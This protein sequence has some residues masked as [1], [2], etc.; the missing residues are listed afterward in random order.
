MGERGIIFDVQ[1]FAVHDGPGIR[2]LVFLKGCPLACQWCSNPESRRFEPDLLFDEAKCIR[3]WSCVPACP[4]AALLAGPEGVRTDRMRC[5]GCGQ[6]VDACCAGARLVKG[7]DV[8]AEWV[9]REVL[10]DEAFFSGSGGGVTLGG[11]EPLA[12]PDFAASIL[13]EAK[14][15]GLHTV[16]ETCGHVPWSAIAQSLPWT[17]LFLFDLKHVDPAK[18]HLYTGGDVSIILSNLRRLAATG[19]PIVIR[20]PVIPTFND[21]ATEI[22]AIANTVAALGL[23]RV[24]LLPYHALGQSKYRLLGTANPFSATVPLPMPA[25]VALKDVAVQAGVNV[26]IEG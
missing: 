9:M 24:H 20:V 13:H 6:C 19:R 17:D 11:G 12:Q 16:V 15:R 3:C 23:Q 14:R 26:Q 21:T 18:H 8:T 1:R 7:M 4:K 5:G 10:K 2:T 25:Y 22:A